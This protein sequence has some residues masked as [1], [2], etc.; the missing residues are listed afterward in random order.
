MPRIAAVACAV[1]AHEAGQGD[2]ESFA[3]RLFGDALPDADR[4][5]GVFRRG[6]VDS[7][8][9]C[10]PLEWFSK[11]RAPREKNDLYI[12]HAEALSREAV[13]RC[14]RQ[15]DLT[16]RDVDHL[17]FVST[18]GMATPSIDARL[19][20]ALGFRRDVKRTPIWGLGCA[21]GAAGLARA[22]DHVRA[23]PGQRALL[24]AVE[25]CGLTFIKDDVSRSNFVAASLFADGAAAVLVD[26]APGPGPRII[27]GGSAL[28]DD[29]LD[30]MGWDFGDDG[31]K[32]VIA[33]EIPAVVARLMR[34]AV[35]SFLAANGLALPDIRR[36]ILHPGG[37]KVLSAYAEALDL[38]QHDLRHSR[39]VL[40]RFGNM[41]SPSVLFVL[42]RALADGRPGDNALLA[43][44]GPGLSCESVLLRW[45]R[46]AA[47]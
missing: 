37:R 47:S 15:A 39:E 4:L 35:E 40:R 13:E 5:A 19:I 34:P 45:D 7:R 9:F 1:P 21:G 41:S 25:L 38:S 43:A 46:Q 17:F 8:R 12:R 44:L 2:V 6:G 22:A 14:L 33:R 23:Y 10:V 31:M 36:F 16:A 30:A 24:V 20:A 28:F 29:S 11:N 3:R 27:A 42:E 18:T 32:V 26:G